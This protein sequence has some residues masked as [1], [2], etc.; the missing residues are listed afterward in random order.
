M[1]ASEGDWTRCGY[2]TRW[3]R[4]TSLLD[5]SAAEV[6]M[7]LDKDGTGVC[8]P[9]GAD[10]VEGRDGRTLVFLHGWTC[11]GTT[12]P[13][14]GTGKWDHKPR[15]RGRRALYAATLGWVGG[16]P[17]VTGWLRPR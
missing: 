9:G 4:S 6:G 5:W 12:D 16:L 7:L 1:L 8:G 15:Q 10:L 2:R 3:M 13:C 11:R 14:A 17:A